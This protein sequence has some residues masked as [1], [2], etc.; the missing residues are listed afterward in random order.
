[1]GKK[2]QSNVRKDDTRSQKKNV[3]ID[4][5]G[6]RNVRQRPKRSK[7]QAEMNN[8]ITEMKK[9]NTLEGVN[10]ITDEKKYTSDLE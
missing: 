4:W 1:M 3:G 5:D 2:I 9:K 8:T 7:E 6:K 10:R